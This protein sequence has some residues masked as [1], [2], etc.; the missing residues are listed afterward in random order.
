MPSIATGDHT[1][2]ATDHRPEDAAG[3]P[4]VLV[5][6]A[7]GSR[8]D[9]PPDLRRLPGGRV[10]TVDLPGHGKSGGTAQ[11]DAAHYVGDLCGLLDTLAVPRAV[12]VGH[13]MGGAV[14]QQMALRAAGRVAGLVLLGTGA[15]LPV[16]SALL[17]QV[18][19][20]YAG[21]VAWI[22]DYA[23]SESTPNDVKMLARD[24]LSQSGAETL[25]A[26]L[27]ACQA[28]DSRADLAMIAVPTLVLGAA[29]DRMVRFSF[30]ETLA[31][32]IP[33]AQ[34]VRI[35]NAGHMFPLECGAK[36]AAII[37]G[38]LEAFGWQTH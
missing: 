6:G 7:G 38:W 23:W 36:V 3:T 20:D 24:R 10:I 4:L 31:A 25:S 1:L 30:S 18:I 32:I 8:L 11:D 14:A 2:Y 17:D 34:L 12:I 13:S 5:H 37:Q 26:D 19:H 29:D 15:R 9:W 27:R 35:E 16:A 28:F 33:N 22:V 21:A